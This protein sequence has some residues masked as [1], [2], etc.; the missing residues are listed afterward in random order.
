MIKDFD[1]FGKPLQYTVLLISLIT[2]VTLTVSEFH[3]RYPW[4][5]ISL[6]VSLFKFEF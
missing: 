4:N 2:T 5:Y 3:R 6:A 1:G